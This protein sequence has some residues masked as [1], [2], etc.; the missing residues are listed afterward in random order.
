MSAE[1]S[2]TEPALP[3]R[4]IRSFVLRQGKMTNAQKRA[5][6]LHWS[7]FGIEYAGTGRDFVALFQRRAER[8]WKSASATASNWPSPP[9]MS[10]NAT[11]SASRCT[12]PASAACSTRSPTAA[13]KTCA[14]T[15][16]TR[17]RCC[18]TRSPTGP[19]TKCASTSPTPGTRSATTSAACCNPAFVAMLCDKLR[20][21]GRCTWPPTG[22]PMRSRC[23]TCARPSRACAIRAGAR[24]SVP[25]P[26]WRRQTHFEDRGQKLGHGVWDLVYERT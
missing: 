18:A 9:P 21:G 12:G 5:F 13:W 11:S 23:W 22:R 4:A 7:K 8:F 26:P 16:T 19:S 2:Q 25:R 14:C 15:S 24:A 20:A 3:R 1:R 6:E 10:R 17:S